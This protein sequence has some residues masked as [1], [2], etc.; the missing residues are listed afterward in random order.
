M[1]R[2]RIV[3][4]P[5]E[6]V[7]RVIVDAISVLGSTKR[8]HVERWSTDVLGCE[9]RSVHHPGEERHRRWFTTPGAACELAARTY[10][11]AGFGVPPIGA[12][13]L[14]T[15]PIQPTGW[16]IADGVRPDHAVREPQMPGTVS[17]TSAQC[18]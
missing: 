2:T 17:A 8:T 13:T 6:R 1:S 12:P 14:L 9:V 3:V 4:T 18:T 7:G 11:I 16:I 5:V 15:R 10:T